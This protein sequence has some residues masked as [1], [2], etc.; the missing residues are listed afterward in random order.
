M[1]IKRGEHEDLNNKMRII[2]MLTDL[3]H[4]NKI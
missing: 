2:K 4:E 1:R 3:G